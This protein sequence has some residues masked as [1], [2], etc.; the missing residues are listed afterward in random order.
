MAAQECQRR[1]GSVWLLPIHLEYPA[2][3]MAQL[4]FGEKLIMLYC[5]LWEE[6]Q[7][8]SSTLIAW[9]PS[10]HGL[11]AILSCT[12][13]FF[14]EVLNGLPARVLLY[15]GEVRIWGLAPSSLALGRYHG[16]WADGPSLLP[17]KR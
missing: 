12:R 15:S 11:Y 1:D 2:P 17:W 4:W 9:A 7:P 8:G 3:D 14:G 6:R 16:D 10:G 13:R 5:I